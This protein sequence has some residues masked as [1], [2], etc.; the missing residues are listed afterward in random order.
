VSVGV[1]QSVSRLKIGSGSSA[2]LCGV[3]RVSNKK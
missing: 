1:S 2:F 3:C